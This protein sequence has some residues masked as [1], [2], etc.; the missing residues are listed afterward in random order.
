MNL[1]LVLG[2]ILGYDA[3]QA[4]TFTGGELWQ[5]IGEHYSEAYAARIMRYVLQ[6]IAQVLLFAC[7]LMFFVST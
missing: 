4:I 1:S 5:H 2:L 7:W 3:S 6:T